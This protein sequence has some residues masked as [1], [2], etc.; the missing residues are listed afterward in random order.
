ML[1]EAF[2]EPLTEERMEIYIRRLSDISQERLRLCFQRALNQLTWF[3][4]L[5]ELRSLAG[6]D[7]D[8]EKK[9][10]ADAAW[11]HVND[12]L[13]KWGVDLLPIYSG[14]NKTSPPPL[15]PHIE[16]ALRRIG[17]LHALNQMDVAKMPFMYRD[18]CEAYNQ[19]PLAELMAPRLEQQFGN[20]KLLGTIKDLSKAKS[21]GRQPLEKGPVE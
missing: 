13:R 15:D 21:M 4:K 20:N 1:A 18:F 11:T 2:A 16:Y 7:A 14:G 12:Y 6:A 19:A 3:P 17:G 9:I 5:A 8:S 10:E